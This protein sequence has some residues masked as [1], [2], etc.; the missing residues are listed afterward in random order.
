M[1]QCRKAMSVVSLV[2]ADHA[3]GTD[4]MYTR[5]GLSTL[6]HS[7]LLCGMANISNFEP[8]PRT[9]EK[10]HQHLLGTKNA[11]MAQ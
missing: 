6:R 1:R 4:C 11:A 8:F 9:R 2:I 7:W 3:E 5:Y 10:P